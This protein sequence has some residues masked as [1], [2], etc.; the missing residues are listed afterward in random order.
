MNK[1]YLLKLQEQANLIVEQVS[2]VIKSMTTDNPLVLFDKDNPD[3]DTIYDLPIGYYVDKYDTYKQGAIHTV[4]GNDVTIF[5][6]GEDFG[7]TFNLELYQLPF[8][9]LI[10]LL[11]YLSERK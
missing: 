2:I 8:E 6:T 4:N 5:F 11:T 3:M 1:E 10:E 7:D 9:S